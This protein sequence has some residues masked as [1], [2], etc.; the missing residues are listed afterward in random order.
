MKAL[1]GKHGYVVPCLFM[2][3]PTCASS[4]SFSTA[5]RP[6]DDLIGLFGISQVDEGVRTTG[7]S[8]QFALLAVG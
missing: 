2:T 5:R 3:A 4:L 6:R 1:R 8:W 7:S